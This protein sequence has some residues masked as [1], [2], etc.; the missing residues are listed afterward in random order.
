MELIT[1]KIN[2][3]NISNTYKLFLKS[4]MTLYSS[5]LVMKLFNNSRKLF[6]ASKLEKCG[7]LIG[8]TGLHMMVDFRRYEIHTLS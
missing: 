2:A 3:Y 1:K 6:Y 4:K 5:A 7:M 8:V